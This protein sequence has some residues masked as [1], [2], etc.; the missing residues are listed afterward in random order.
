MVVK[1]DNGGFD[2][3]KKGNLPRTVNIR[4]EHG[5]VSVM[6]YRSLKEHEETIIAD[7]I[8]HGY[9]HA[10]YT[11]AEIDAY[12]KEAT[13]EWRDLKDKLRHNP[14]LLLVLDRT[15]ERYVPYA[16]NSVV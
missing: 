11:E 6:P 5:N 12:E 7:N 15:T 14:E 8:F 16:E 10:E 1:R 4:D 13:Q 2:M 9:M 3:G